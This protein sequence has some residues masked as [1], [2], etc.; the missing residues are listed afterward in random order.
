MKFAIEATSLQKRDKGIAEK[1][2]CLKDFNLTWGV[3]H[4]SCFDWP[5]EVVPYITIE[6]PGD[7]AMLI[8]STGEDI[9]IRKKRE[10]EQEEYETDFIIEIYDDWRE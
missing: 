6:T 4:D 10:W 9:I 7:L 5:D 3:V 8:D 2:P 1:Y